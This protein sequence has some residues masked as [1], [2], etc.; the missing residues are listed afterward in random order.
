MQPG[1]C[2]A[3]GMPQSIKLASWNVNGIR[4]AERKGFLDWFHDRKYHI[5]GIQET[6]AH[7]EQLSKALTHPDGYES[8]WCS[9]VKKG[10]SGT[11]VYTKISPTFAET[12]FGDPFLD[13]EGRM[14][15]LEFE[16]FFFFNVYFPNG[17]MSPERLHHKMQFYKRF[18]D[19]AES[20]RK[21][22]PIVMCGDV[23]TAHT[24]IDLARPK[25]NAHISGF[26]PEERKW[27]DTLVGSGYH[28]TFRLFQKDGG[29]YSWWDMKSGARARNV[30]WRIDYFFV[31]DELKKHVKKAWIEPDVLGSDHCPVGIELSW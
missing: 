2:Y 25:E 15:L 9:A 16:K 18:L 12:T 17:K 10:Y 6:K 21:K 30:G 4:A 29:Y 5:V 23:N 27:M 20:Y 8:Y 26:L 24:E 11:A 14:I 28:D 22:K 31:S 7:V 3:L 13:G 19:L 1:L